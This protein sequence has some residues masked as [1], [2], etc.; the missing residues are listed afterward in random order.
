MT[1]STKLTDIKRVW[2]LIDVKGK[3]L[4]RISTDI[5]KLLM[6][7]GKPYFVKNLDCGDYVVVVNAKEV[8]L[9]GNKEKQK[10]Y[11]SYSGYPGGLSSETADKVRQRKPEFL[12]EHAVKG[13][14]PQTKLR[15]RML[16]RL[17]VFADET[18]PYKEKLGDK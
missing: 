10:T 2:H 9:T 16:R 1:K 4:G 15:D 17:Y 8:V 12:V 11:Y 3:P 5:A 14:L 6:G 18:H 7:K 13:M